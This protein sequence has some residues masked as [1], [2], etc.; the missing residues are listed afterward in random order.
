MIRFIL[1]RIR[2]HLFRFRNRGRI[3]LSCDCEVENTKFEGKNSIASG[4]VLLSCS[5]GFATYTNRN[6]RLSF[7][8]VGR[9]SSIADN[10]SVVLGN[11]PVDYV[12]TFPSFYYDTSKQIG[13]AIHRGEPLFK[14]IFKYPKGENFYQVVIGNDVWIGSHAL[15]MGGVS[16]G[17]GAVVAAGSV[18]TKDVEPY[19]I[20]GGVPARLIRYRFPNDIK[21]KLMNIKWWEK[22]L[23]EINNDYLSYCNVE[24][25]LKL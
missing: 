17:D 14:D 1:A 8:K 16:I 23:N 15:I 13:F 4:S 18:V 21:T 10:V 11:H 22:P 9:F 5:L 19:A 6:V 12:T 3:K 25:F 2:F 7:V 24:N 20:V